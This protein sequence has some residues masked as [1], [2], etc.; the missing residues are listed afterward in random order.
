VAVAHQQMPVELEAGVL[1]VIV[2]FLLKL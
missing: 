1:V 2:N